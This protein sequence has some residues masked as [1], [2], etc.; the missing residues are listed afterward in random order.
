VVFCEVEGGAVL[1]STAQEVYFGLNP[2]GVQVWNLLP[3]KHST[4]EELVGILAGTYP[5]VERTV[6]EEDVTALL[7]EL[8]ASG[9]VR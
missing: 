9:L 2:V 1:L 6:L 5:D 3:P 8:K 7:D 4:V